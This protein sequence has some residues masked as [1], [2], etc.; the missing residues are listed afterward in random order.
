MASA[1][2]RN[3]AASGERQ[4]YFSEHTGPAW[5]LMGTPGPH[6]SAPRGVEA[7]PLVFI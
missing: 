7:G 1:L 3:A 2:L 4:Q 6:E 5:Q